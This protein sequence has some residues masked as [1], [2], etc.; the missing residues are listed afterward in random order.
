MC[1]SDDFSTIHLP[2]LTKG[3]FFLLLGP[4]LAENL[5]V[6]HMPITKARELSIHLSGKFYYLS[7][8]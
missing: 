7:S 3:L 4:F 6:Q 2:I 8:K 5:P 1:V